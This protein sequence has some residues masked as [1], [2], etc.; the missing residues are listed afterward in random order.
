[1]IGLS[2]GITRGGVASNPELVT[3]GTFDSDTAWTKGA[4]VTITGGEA[5]IVGGATIL[6][7]DIG[8]VVGETYNVTFDY[9]MS[10][11]AKLRIENSVT[12][13]AD[14]LA[15]T[16]ALGASGTVSLS[17]VPTVGSVFVIGADTA[18][19]SGTIDNVSVQL[20]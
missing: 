6:T 13:G 17:I 10:A 9:T 8:M 20:A 15:V 19:F 16:D 14:I 3:N 5:V 2:L 11:G 7:Q 12:P 1:M 4:G 18:T